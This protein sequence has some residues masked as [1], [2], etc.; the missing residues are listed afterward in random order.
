M[1]RRYPWQRW[2]GHQRRRH[3]FMRAKADQVLQLP[4]W[5]R[6]AWFLADALVRVRAAMD[7]AAC[8][9]P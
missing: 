2:A 5:W 4:D 6:W 9:Q 8:T 3:A 7:A 1:D